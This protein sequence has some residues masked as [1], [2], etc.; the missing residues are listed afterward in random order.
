MYS[1]S[2][3]VINNV[4]RRNG[5][6]K[7]LVY[8]STFQNKKA[9]YALSCETLRYR[10]V[11]MDIANHC[12]LIKD[13][14]LKN[15]ENLIAVLLYEHLLGKGIKGKHKMII[16]KYK[17]S[18]HSRCERLKLETGTTD[19][20]N[21]LQKLLPTSDEVISLPKYVRINTLCANKDD[22]I[23]ELNQQFHL[24]TSNKLEEINQFVYDNDIPDLLKFHP[25]V[26]L[27]HNPLYLSG[28]LIIQDKA[29]C[30]PAYILNP[31]AGSQV[32]DCCAAPG[33]KTTHLAAIMNN[34]GTIFAFDKDKK[35]V[36]ILQT[37]V[38]KAKAT[39]VRAECK[40]FLSINPMD[41]LYRKV[42]Y[43]LVDPSC[44]G[45]GMINRQQQFTDEV[46]SCTDKRLEQLSKFQISIV[47]HALSFPN[48]RRVVYSTCSIHEQENELVVEEV[49]SKFSDKFDVVEVMPG[50]KFRGR[51]S[52]KNGRKCL[53]MS[54]EESQ[55]NGFFVACFERIKQ[56]DNV[57]METLN[58]VNTVSSQC[59]FKSE[60]SPVKV[61]SNK[62]MRN[63]RHTR[64]LKPKS[65]KLTQ[66]LRA[67]SH[68][69]VT[70]VS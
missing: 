43:V 7:N 68:W 65:K 32:I 39:C 24:T 23:T 47:K 5:S 20:K 60:N 21:A 69:D 29:S 33:N 58:H 26:D 51:D 59:S 6:L 3:N 61:F 19:I 16:Q 48:V 62:N 45:S 12:A 54:Y 14:Q 44:S 38:N 56:S 53:R 10:E 36:K 55:T 17:S 4:L 15:N 70:E 41:N 37:M 25:S 1:E 34:N 57:E 49:Y 28:K 42:E 31:P 63:K 30:F 64:T 67:T 46:K 8:S 22:I 40:D 9:L 52:Y 18:I 66:T 13:K 35:R 11:L 2:A 50:W 27:H